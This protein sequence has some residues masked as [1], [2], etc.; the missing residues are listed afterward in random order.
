MA[1]PVTTVTAISVGAAAGFHVLPHTG[2]PSQEAADRLMPKAA[3]PGGGSQARHRAQT[4]SRAEER[5]TLSASPS[6]APSV[7]LRPAPSPPAVAGHRYLTA[8]LNVWTGPSEASRFVHVLPTGSRVAV[9][10]RRRAG[11]AEI[12]EDRQAR[13]V[14]AAY[15]SLTKPAP[16][17]PTASDPS[18]PPPQRTRQPRPPAAGSSTAA[19][20]AGES[21]TPTRSSTA[22]PSPTA[23]ASKSTGFSDAPCPDGS[24]V[25]NGL[26]PTA[27]GVYRAVCAQFPAVTTYGGYR[28]DGSEHSDGTSVDIMVYSDSSLGDRIASWLRANARTLHVREVIWSQHIW[29]VERSSEGWRLMEDR[30]STTANHYD[31]VHVRVYS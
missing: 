9:T 2:S 26:V 11:F 22:T 12:V 6:H 4:V 5:V 16:P 20:P 14:H 13:W 19:G 17:E 27:V 30:G 29:T 21:G 15:L 3:V 8:P 18:P 1:V 23:S 24:A 28:D 31:H 7:R 25:E 10:G